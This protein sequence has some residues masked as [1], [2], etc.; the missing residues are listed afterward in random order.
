METFLSGY[1]EENSAH[2]TNTVS[3]SI[4]NTAYKRELWF[5]LYYNPFIL[6]NLRRGIAWRGVV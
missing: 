4:R 5:L 1:T 3:L 2:L 6:L